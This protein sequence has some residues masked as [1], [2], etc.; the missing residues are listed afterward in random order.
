VYVFVYICIFLL[1]NIYVYICVYVCTYTYLLHKS[2]I[3]FQAAADGEKNIY[4]KSFLKS[5]KNSS[6]D[7]RKQPSWKREHLSKGSSQSEL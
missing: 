1:I 5:N 2:V 7:K 6:I 4:Y 3:Y